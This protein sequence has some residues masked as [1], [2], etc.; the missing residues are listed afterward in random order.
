MEWQA[1]TFR[2]DPFEKQIGDGAGT[3]ANFQVFQAAIESLICS[4]IDTT[5]ATDGRKEGRRC[6]PARSH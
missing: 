5:N 3:V 1:G 6:I 2:R 4:V